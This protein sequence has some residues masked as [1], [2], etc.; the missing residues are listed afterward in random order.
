[1]YYLRYLLIY[2]LGTSLVLSFP[3]NA[4]CWLVF[5]SLSIFVAGLN[6]KIV[7]SSFWYGYIFYLGASIAFIGYW[8][9]CY[10]RLQL[11][12]SYILSY[13]LTSIICLYTSLYIGGI[14]TLY[15]R[16][17]TSNN[18][19]NLCFL[20]PSLWVITELIRGL[21]FPRSWYALGNTQVDNIVFRGYYPLFGA[22]F[23]SWLII[24]ISGFIAYL[25]IYKRKNIK[26]LVTGILILAIWIVLSL[27]L[28]QIR[29]TH[30]YGKPISVALLQPSIFSSTNDGPL[31][32]LQLENIS[33]ELIKKANADLIVLPE[34]V[35]GT[36]SENLSD[37]YL[38]RIKSEING[39]VLIYGS[40]I[41]RSG[42]LHQTGIVNINDPGSLIY[43]K[44]YLVPFGEYTPFKNEFMDSLVN[45]VGF[46]IAEYIPGNYI[47]QPT[48]I[49]G[50]K[51]AFNLCYENA[52]NA[53]VAD[54][55]KNS[56]I[57]LNQSDLS[58]YGKTVMKDA[59]L[60]FSQGRALE[61]Q[62]Y[63]LQDGNTGDTVIINPEGHVEKRLEAFKSGLLIGTVHG[64]TGTTPFEL[65]CNTPIWLLC[66]FI[67]IYAL[68]KK[69]LFLK[70]NSNK[71][72]K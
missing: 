62:R 43:A 69:K 34:T 53:F 13:I 52:I 27:L 40:P 56:T 23:V 35:F 48:E 61:N 44:Y 41:N 39:K 59:S 68:L 29:Y 30:E 66:S 63:F 11:G 42:Y 26:S 4:V 51:F 22:Y 70:N 3:P 6:S 7:K 58:W 28:S 45:N 67:C 14:S 20:F 16:I 31:K 38:D 46:Q 2:L 10:F 33:E 5:I 49:L 50:Q 55:A 8:F 60:Q 54:N 72:I 57:L 19:F 65:W 64:Y 17:K 71:R 37:G 24:S 21:F 32:L 12:T 47:Q 36:D 15:T 25:L 1:M 18:V 9:S